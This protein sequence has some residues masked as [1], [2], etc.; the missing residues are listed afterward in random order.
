MFRRAV[1]LIWDDSHRIEQRILSILHKEKIIKHTAKQRH[2]RLVVK[3]NQLW[4]QKEKEGCLDGR[5]F[6]GVLFLSRL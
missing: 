6:W 2:I 5:S 4:D 1:E 3:A